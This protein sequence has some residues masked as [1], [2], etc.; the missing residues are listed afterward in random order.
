MK[1]TTKL[2][3][4]IGFNQKLAPYV[5]VSPFFILFLIFGLYPLVYS[6]YMS[7]FDMR[8]VG[9]RGFVGLANYTRLFTVDEFFTTAIIN[10]VIL[11][12]FGSVL[13]HFIAI[14]LA[15]LVNSKKVRGRHLFKTLFFAPYITS[16]VATVII[17]GMVF[18]HNHGMLNWL[19]ETVFQ[20]EG[21]F[22]WTTRSGPIKAAIAIMLNWRF[23]GFNMVIYLAGLQSIPEELY[24]AAEMDG[25]S[26]LR[27]H[28]HITLP[29]L[30]PIIFFG[31]T[32]SIIGG[33]QLFDEPFILM[34]G[35][36]TLGGPGQGGL[37]IAYY[38]MFLGF[39]NGRLG[40]GAAVAWVLFLIIIIFTYIN[41]KVT[42]RLQR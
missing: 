29:M 31:L 1:T 37:T 33:F 34:G 11:L 35:Y 38:L 39:R 13:Q 10:T 23:I 12:I 7:F 16:A 5:F 15:I 4:K 36:D 21:G 32:L 2:W 20:I 26:T 28:L 40:R 25:A 17:F 42:N 41:R 19:L 9:N 6:F 8:L 18:D 3:E 24:E 14:P 22:R 30:I 27:Q